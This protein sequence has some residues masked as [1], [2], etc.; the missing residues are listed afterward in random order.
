MKWKQI[1]GFTVLRAASLFTLITDYWSNSRSTEVN[2]HCW[3]FWLQIILKQ[4]I[5]DKQISTAVVTTDLLVS[6]SRALPD[7]IKKYWKILKNHIQEIKLFQHFV[8]DLMKNS[9]A[10]FV[11]CLTS[12]DGWSNH[13]KHQPDQFSTGHRSVRHQS[14]ER[15]NP[16]GL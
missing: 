8:L 2:C 10:R 12:S 5:S 7:S 9:W 13:V 4:K 16:E 1:L 11:L 15:C 3:Y 14:P 6:I